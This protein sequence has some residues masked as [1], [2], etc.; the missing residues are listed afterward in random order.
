MKRSTSYPDSYDIEPRSLSTNSNESAISSRV[1]STPAPPPQIPQIPLQQSFAQMVSLKS[2]AE[3]EQALSQSPEGPKELLLDKICLDDELFW[4]LIK[5]KLEKVHLQNCTFDPQ[6]SISFSNILKFLK[7]RHLL[8]SPFRFAVQFNGYTT[9]WDLFDEDSNTDLLALE[10]ISSLFFML[11]STIPK[12]SLFDDISSLVFLF[13]KSSSQ[14]IQN[15]PSITRHQYPKL[16][17][18]LLK[19]TNFK[20]DIESFISV[21]QLKLDL[22]Y[23]WNS[24]FQAKDPIWS[25]LIRSMKVV[26]WMHIG[27][28]QNCNFAIPINGHTTQIVFNVDS[29]FLMSNS[30][31]LVH[32][33]ILALGQDLPGDLSLDNVSQLTLFPSKTHLSYGQLSS[34]NKKSLKAMMN[35]LH[36]NLKH[37]LLI[38]I[39]FDDNLEE[40]IPI[41][42]L[43]LDLIFIWNCK[44][45]TNDLIWSVL[46]DLMKLIHSTYAGK[47]QSCQFAIPINGH[48]THILINNDLSSFV[49][50]AFNLAH[51]L[52][53]H[54]G[55]VLPSNLLVGAIDFLVLL[56]S[57]SD[58]NKLSS[59]QSKPNLD[60]IMDCQW[61]KLKYLLLKCI[62]IDDVEGMPSFIRRVR[63]LRVF[64]L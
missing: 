40:Y 35:R 36:P 53:L 59:S 11:P 42:Q 23:L 5:S 4:L 44:F 27:K 20:G 61:S 32:G 25:A 62:S 29:S 60:S 57:E 39:D 51:G 3:V 6:D 54:L 56:P 14:S 63:N 30:S 1:L 45:E 47:I 21:S 43:K 15:L 31:E 33:L 18:L 38:H 46:C 37:L 13:S 50:N 19:D 49:P 41:P 55:Q 64:T 26:N 17:Y 34:Q 16:K 2:K 10:H 58:P 24:D 12:K 7:S 8:K 9:Q 28:G 52:V 22:I 48:T